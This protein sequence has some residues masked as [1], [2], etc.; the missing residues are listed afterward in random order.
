MIEDRLSNSLINMGFHRINSNSN[1]IYMFYQAGERGITIVSVFHAINGDELS[2]TQ[3]EHIRN[4]MKNNFRNSYSGPVSQLNLILTVNPD[5]AKQL[6]SASGDDSHWIIDLRQNR[7]MIY[8]TGSNGFTDFKDKVEQMLD[9]EM[10]ERAQHTQGLNPNWQTQEPRRGQARRNMAMELL[11][12]VNVVIILV[13]IIVFIICHYTGILGTEEEKYVK[14]ALSWYFIK[15]NQEYYRLLT[16]MFMHSDWSHLFNNMLVLLFIG[17]HLE[18]ITGKWR[19]VFIY[20]G[21]GILAGTTSISYNMWKEDILSASNHLTLSIGASGAVFGVVGAMLYIVIVN[22][23]RLRDISRS[24]MILFV[25]LS[26]YSGIA[27]SQI[28]Q[29]AHIGGFL[30]GVLL[31]AVLYRRP[32]YQSS[33][34]EN[35]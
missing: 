30:A 23:G 9:E 11:T 7:L 16:S 19:Y 4:Q 3:Y 6:C 13:N 15:E 34:H 25:I 33:G 28:D 26:L 35:F 12:P 27:N 24:R 31:A 22:K 29:A 20:F 5:R 32:K 17:N 1:G 2:L 21:T 10:Q 14:G 18:R 8:E